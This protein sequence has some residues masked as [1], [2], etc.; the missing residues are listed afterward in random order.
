M[1]PVILPAVC[2]RSL[3]IR[4]DSFIKRSGGVRMELRARSAGDGTSAGLIEGG[5]RGET[6][7]SSRVCLIRDSVEAG[8]GA[9]GW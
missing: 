4:S 3:F 7:R 5:P 2:A 6:R 1:S 9:T 8:E